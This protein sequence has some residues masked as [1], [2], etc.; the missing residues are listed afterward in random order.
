M[1]IRPAARSG[2]Q[3]LKVV[4]QQFCT[5]SAGGTAAAANFGSRFIFHPWMRYE[6]AV[7]LAFLV[8]LATCFLLMADVCV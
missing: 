4:N 3:A 7:R 6:W 1:A 2:V 8:G 5:T